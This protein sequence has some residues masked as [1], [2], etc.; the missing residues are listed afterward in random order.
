[1]SAMPKIFLIYSRS[2]SLIPF[3]PQAFEILIS[4]SSIFST[5]KT[6]APSAG[7]YTGSYRIPVFIFSYDKNFLNTG[8]I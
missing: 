2:L 1:M 4:K 3:K 7:W 6:L 8:V 5:K